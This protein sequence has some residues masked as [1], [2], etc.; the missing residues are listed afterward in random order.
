[1]FRIG[2]SL[3]EVKTASCLQ[4]QSSNMLLYKCIGSLHVKSLS[5]QQAL[6]FME[7]PQNIRY[8]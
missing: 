1:M 7:I 6:I 3:N 8:S 2:E 5:Q 4:L